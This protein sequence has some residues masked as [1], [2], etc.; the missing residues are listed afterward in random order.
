MDDLISEFI[1]ETSESLAVLD[2][3]LARL[4]QNPN[5]REILATIFRLVHTIKGTCGFLNLTRLEAV[6]EAVETALG[7]IERGEVPMSQ[8]ASARVL[9]ALA[10]IKH[11]IEHLETHSEEPAGDDA[12]LIAQLRSLNADAAKPV[13]SA[14]PPKQVFAA[15][16]AP[17]HRVS[18][19]VF[20]EPEAFDDDEGPLTMIHAPLIPAHLPVTAPPTVI[21]S[22][23]AERKS[24]AVESI[25]PQA[26][27][28]AI[29]QGLKTEIPASAPTRWLLDKLAWALSELIAAR[30]QLKVLS[31][32]LQEGTL[33]APIAR[34]GN[35][36]HELAEI[37]QSSPEKSS[38]PVLSV[39]VLSTAG[40]SFALP[41]RY[42]T[43][44]VNLVLGGNFR[45]QTIHDTEVLVIG[46]RVIPLVKLSALLG[47]KPADNESQVVVVKVGDAEYGLIAAEA[48]EEEEVVLSD[49]PRLLKKLD[50]YRG[51]SLAD[52]EQPVL[53][54]DPA[55]LA[56][57]IGYRQVK[58]IPPEQAK[59]RAV[60]HARMAGFLLF[61]AGAGAPKALLLDEVARVAEVRTDTTDMRIANL[62]GHLLRRE[63]GEVIVLAGNGHEKPVA[64]AVDSVMDIVHAPL[65]LKAD[66]HDP[67][68]LGTV[69][70]NGQ[71]AELVDARRF[72]GH[73]VREAA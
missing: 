21:V 6:A 62:P 65:A 11:I 17:K 31:R 9:E 66:A 59:P 22:T 42:I 48:G 12:R 37:M 46:R 15:T 39:L 67:A 50:V 27:Q 45:L 73:S 13:A 2:S 61:R 8:A 35:V 7:K 72:T 43:E 51:A 57:A 60:A 49:M 3:E 52:G 5:D 23:P 29:R 69:N 36:T 16:A 18:E 70:I 20:A 4:D 19:P 41:Q 33:E 1:S 53:V 32:Q 25:S 26:R 56:R 44:V 40:F 71:L 34:I 47:L 68:Y 64:I 58:D 30:K 28:E 14:E 10:A 38:V 24:V 63:G 54:L 55:G